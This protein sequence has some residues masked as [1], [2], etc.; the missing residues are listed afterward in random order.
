MSPNELSW[1]PLLETWAGD[2]ADKDEPFATQCSPDEEQWAKD[3]TTKYFVKPRVW[4]YMERNLGKP[5]LPA[6]EVIRVTQ[7][8]SLLTA[9]TAEY[10]DV[11]QE[12]VDRELFEKLWVYCFAWGIG[13]LFGP[14]DRGKFHRDILEK[15][16][17]PVPQ[18]SQQK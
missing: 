3:L 9:I 4:W 7:M 14:E 17:A 13:G 5:V 16:N 2:R 8:L 6:S 18:I 11:R 1:E 12:V 10:S 15:I